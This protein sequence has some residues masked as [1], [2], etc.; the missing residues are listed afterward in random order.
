MNENTG[1]AKLIAVDAEACDFGFEWP[2]AFMIID[3]VVNECGEVKDAIEQKDS[4]DKIQEEI[5]DLLH[6]AVSLGLFN[7]LDIEE[8]INKA[9]HKL[10]TRIHTLKEISKARGLN[11]LKDQTIEFKLQ[12]WREVKAKLKL[13][14]EA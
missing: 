12:L 8:T 3:Q 4:K 6:A 1:L 11:S 2:D 5:G 13:S 14:Q 10:E 7:G 9:A